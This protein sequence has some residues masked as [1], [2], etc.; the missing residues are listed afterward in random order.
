[1]V[2]D[3]ESFGTLVQYTD[4]SE[5]VF[6][7]FSINDHSPDRAHEI[8]SGDRI[9]LPPDLRAWPADRLI[10]HLR[11]RVT[12]RVLE[13]FELRISDARAA[14]LISDGQGA[15]EGTMYATATFCFPAHLCYNKMK[16]IHVPRGKALV[17]LEGFDCFCYYAPKPPKSRHEKAVNHT[18]DSTHARKQSEINIFLPSI[19]RP[20]SGTKTPRY[21]QSYDAFR[22]PVLP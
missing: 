22:A 4:D 6:N 13:A 14:A 9:G 7:E 17:R 18:T 16:R 3:V 12:V 20:K 15:S 21:G 2:L 1:M 5:F 8:A 11:E 19:K 10:E